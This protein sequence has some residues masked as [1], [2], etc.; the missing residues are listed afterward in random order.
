MDRHRRFLRAKYSRIGYYTGVLIIGVGVYTLLPLVFYPFTRSQPGVATGFIVAGF[1]GMLVGWALTAL[2]RRN[3]ADQPP[4]TYKEGAVVVTATWLIAVAIGTLP[5]VLSGALGWLDATYEAMSGWT[6]TGLSMIDA[7]A[8]DPLLLAW[9]SLMQFAGGAGLAVMMLAALIGPIGSR[10]Y[11]A[12]ARGD[13]LVP[14]VVRTAKLIMGIYLGYAVIGT[15]AYFAAGMSW[16]DAVNHSIAALST[17]GFST[18]NASIGHWQSPAIEAVSLALMF[19]GTTSFAVH[20][21]LLTRKKA[22]DHESVLLGAIILVAFPMFLFS[23]SQTGF[24][25]VR[26]ALFNVIS[27]IS[28]TGFATV[29]FGELAGGPVFLIIMLMAIGGGTGATAGGIKLHRIS[30]LLHEIW[31]SIKQ[32]VSPNRM[33]LSRRIHRFG[34]MERIPQEAFREIGLYVG[35]VLITLGLGTLIFTLYG[36]PVKTALFEFGSSLGTVGLSTGATNAA[37]PAGLKVVQMLAMWLGRLEF[38][39]IFVA[40]A[41]LFRDIGGRRS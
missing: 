24:E 22:R 32:E 8:A 28:T 20:Y 34:R 31:W 29:D 15:V 40:F 35:L 38:F 23:L 11:G 41:Q 9:R 17:G 16:F 36:Y 2:S 30:L 7:D 10:L 5:F 21:R 37:M 4:L 13:H 18:K 6:T 14:N 25:A 39:A 3:E 1:L 33:V 26:V 27:A 19:A 12:E